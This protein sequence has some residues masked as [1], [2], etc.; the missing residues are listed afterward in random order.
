M[1]TYK[2]FLS[3]PMRILLRFPV[4]FDLYLKVLQPQYRGAS[5]LGI[6]GNLK[7]SGNFM[8][9]GKGQG[10]SWNLEKSGNFNP[11]LGKV[12]EFYLREMN[13]AEV[14]HKNKLMWMSIFIFKSCTWIANFLERSGK[15][16]GILKS[17][18]AGHSVFTWFIAQ[19]NILADW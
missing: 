18:N 15:S 2:C 7:K 5:G 10:I 1:I 4:A 19:T 11:K 17:W 3:A 8:T 14:L 12:R 13:I 9:L 16:Q 6:S